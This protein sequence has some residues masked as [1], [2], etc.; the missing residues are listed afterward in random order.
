[1]ASSD[2]DAEVQALLTPDNARFEA[3][4]QSLTSAD[5]DAR[6]KAEAVFAGLRGRPDLCAHYLVSTLRGCASVQH[7]SF[8]AVMIRKV[9]AKGDRPMWPELSKQ[10]QD[11]MKNELLNSVKEERERRVVRKV[12]DAVSELAAL[13]LDGDG[14]PEIIPFIFQCVQSGQAHLMESGLL[15]LSDFAQKDHHDSLKEYS[16][17]LLQVLEACLKHQAGD[18]KLAAFGATCAVVQ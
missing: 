8:C 15:I 18:V 16:G 12:C 14:W 3:L 2:I 7:R 10:V 5:N 6:G 17:P 1:M 4:L 11:L 13:A 9:L